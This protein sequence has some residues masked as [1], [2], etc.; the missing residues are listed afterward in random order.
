LLQLELHNDPRSWLAHPLH[1]WRA[2]HESPPHASRGRVFAMSA[3][4]PPWTN[5]ALRAAIVVGA[6]SALA[7]LVGTMI[8]VRTPWNT[9]Q[10]QAIDQPVEFDHRHHV[11]DDQIDCIYC[12]T[13]A[14]TS[15]FAG[16][17][18]TDVCMGCHAQI[19]N[20]SPL[21]ENVRRSYFS[22]QPLP[23]NRVHD[24]G[25]FAYFDH[26]V[27][28]RRGLGCVRCHGRVEQMARV[29]KVAPLTMQWCLDC[30]RSFEADPQTI[31]APATDTGYE[32]LQ[33]ALFEVRVDD[34]LLRRGAVSA[35][36]TCTACH[37]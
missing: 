21:L 30:H 2:T 27:H 12:H 28:V 14:E 25:D 4:F 8:Y 35:L 1:H 37:R 32:A 19:W 17:P 9:E 18:G 7:T 22:N 13:G 6:L 34:E 20:D 36:T 3:L 29:E 31:P 5:T 10:D 26:A 16:V 11:G 15:R 33:G 23:W 24:V